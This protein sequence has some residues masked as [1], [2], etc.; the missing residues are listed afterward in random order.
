MAR[1]PFHL[2]ARMLKLP[3]DQKGGAPFDRNPVQSK[4]RFQ[5]GGNTGITI[6]HCLTMETLY[7]IPYAPPRR[8]SY[9][10]EAQIGRP[11]QCDLTETALRL[12]RVSHPSAA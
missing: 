3:E 10:V 1:A 7:S 5:T 4:A 12:W 11:L 6:G 8:A 2:P 9:Q